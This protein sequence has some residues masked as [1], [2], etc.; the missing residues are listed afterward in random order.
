MTS[1]YF[2]IRDQAC[3]NHE[4]AYFNQTL[5]G[6]VIVH[7]SKSQRFK[8][9]ACQKTWVGYRHEPQ[10]GLKSDTQKFFRVQ[11]LLSNGLSIRTVAQVMEVSP[12]TVVRWKGRFRV[13]SQEISA[14]AV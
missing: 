9:K 3:P 8:C 10:Y 1:T 5:G 14:G 13:A 12:S 6:N 2:S 7:S 4:C 11:T